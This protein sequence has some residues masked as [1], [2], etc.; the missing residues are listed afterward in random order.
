MIVS[1]IAAADKKGVIGRAGGLPWRLPDELKRF[2]ALTIRVSFFSRMETRKNL[3]TS[4]RGTALTVAAGL[5]SSIDIS[6]IENIPC[7]K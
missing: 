7:P 5:L 4:C 6:T 1:L 2:K 3:A